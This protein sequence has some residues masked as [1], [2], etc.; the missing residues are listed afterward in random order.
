MKKLAISLILVCCIA[1]TAG[2][3]QIVETFEGFP[4]GTVL[5]TQIPGLTISASTGTATVQTASSPVVPGEPQGLAHL[6]YFDYPDYLIIDFSPM[7][8]FVGAIVDFGQVDSGVMLTVYDGPGGTG[9]LL[10]SM[11]TTDEV[12]ISVGG[13]TIASARF[14]TLGEDTYLID[15]LT[16][17]QDTVATESLSWD[18]IKS[19]FR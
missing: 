15:N 16:Y 11:A 13:V 1:T 18:E 5:T 8:S 6:P 14:E 10:G 19:L 2:A 3:V 12:F 17:D 4:V 9:N 7:V